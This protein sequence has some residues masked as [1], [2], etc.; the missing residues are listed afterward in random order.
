M[1]SPY[2][3]SMKI[4]PSQ[5]CYKCYLSFTYANNNAFCLL[6]FINNC[7]EWFKSAKFIIFQNHKSLS[8]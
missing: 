1:Q 4:I 8:I 6:F 7:K 5:I 2:M 3:Q